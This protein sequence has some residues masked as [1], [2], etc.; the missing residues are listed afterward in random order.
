[1]LPAALALASLSCGDGKRKPGTDGG[2]DHQPPPPSGGCLQ[3]SEGCPCSKEGAVVACGITV[4]KD[5]DMLTCREGE[6]TCLDGEWS[7]CLGDRLTQIYDGAPQAPGIKTQALATA[8]ADCMDKC[9]PYCRKLADTPEDLNPGTEFTAA[10]SGLTLHTDGFTSGNCPDVVI[11]PETATIEITS[12]TEAAGVVTLTPN[13]VK[14]SATC[15]GGVSIDPSW[16]TDQTDRSWVKPDG[17]VTVSSAIPGPITVTGSSVVDTDTSVVTVKVNVNDADAAVTPAIKTQFTGPG[18]MADPNIT[19]YP[20]NDT[21]FPLDLKAPVVQWT[22][23]GVTAANVEVSLRYPAGSATPTF[24]YSKIYDGQPTQGPVNTTAGAPAWAI[25]QAVW[26]AFGRTA[27]GNDAEIIIQRRTASTLYQPRTIRVKFASAPL[28]GTVYYTQYIRSL[29][30]PGAGLIQSPQADLPDTYDPLNPGTTVCPVGNN[31]HKAGS[32]TRAIDMSTPT[33]N[34]IDPFGGIQSPNGCPVC[35]SVSANGNVYVAG[36]NF[37]QQDDNN[38]F[39]NSISVTA[40]GA[41]FTA[42]GEAP[43]YATLRSVGSDW[44]SRGFA[45]AALTPDGALAIQGP[46]WW[47]NTAPNG[48]NNLTIDRSWSQNGWIRPMFFVPTATIGA[49]V[50]Y[51]TTTNLSATR[52]GNVLTGPAATT[53]P[54]IDGASMVVGDSVLV[55]DQT[56]KKDNG[57][58]EVSTLGGCGYGT[59]L[60]TSTALTVTVTSTNGTNTGAKAIDDNTTTRWE[61]SASDPQSITIDLG[62]SQSIGRVYIDWEA[63]SA[64]DYTIQVATA[65]AGPWTT[66]ATMTN[67]GSTNHRIDDLRCLS[68]TGRYVR[69]AGTARST[70]YGYSIFEM[71]V[72]GPGAT[73]GSAYTLTRRSD[74]QT[75]AAFDGTIKKDWEVR[76]TRGTANYAKVFRLTAPAANPSINTD[77]LT[78]T[79]INASQ[80]P[81]MT[82][83]AI[84]PDGTKV[85]YVNGDADAIGAA[86]TAWRKGLTMLTLN[87]ATRQVS[88]K[89]RLVDNWNATTGGT[90]VKWPFFERDSRSVVYV[91][92]D[93]DE[94]C[95]SGGDY[96]TDQ[97]RACFGD[98]QAFANT[99]PTQRGYWPGRLFSVDSQNPATTKTELAKLNNGELAADNAKAFQ[100]TVLPFASGGYRWVIFTS[101]RSY[102]NQLNQLS[103][104]GT[105]TNF[106]CSA[107][108]LWI[109]AVDDS[110][111]AGTDRSHPAFL[112]PGQNLAPITQENHYLNERGYLV[113]SPCRNTGLSCETDDQCCGTY[114]CQVDTISA[115]GVPMKTCKNSSDCSAEGGA[116]LSDADCCGGAP[117]NNQK[118]QLVPSY[119]EATYQRTFV[120]QC[121]SGYKPWWGQ[122]AYHLT[123][124][125]GSH[126][127]FTAQTA[128]TSADLATATVVALKDETGS[129]FGG[130]AFTIDVGAKLVAKPVSPSLSYLRIS[131]T[132]TPSTGGAVS[133]TLHDWEQRFSCLPAE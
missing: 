36:S 129:N 27:A 92:T 89:T 118:C 9:E 31:T 44:D 112:L 110:T 8:A 131:M 54:T 30:T 81:V 48:G 55:K 114:K 63:A 47:G 127:N 16:K 132:F 82:M 109:A 28:R 87:Q 62:S 111:A 116:C 72:Y 25:P 95:R 20:Y 120:A 74:A 85:V 80:L 90:P 117:C 94:W 19:L 6:R 98:G 70:T 67:G 59:N 2:P 106:T 39:V 60:T 102:G 130:T 79:D 122:F 11:T 71:D 121:D 108:L 99:A 3:P 13:S 75:P 1:V 128:A 5:E 45:F 96:S 4:S 17:T 53:L 69:M 78:F 83:P 115:S 84:S 21:I 61:S 97:G 64:K 101:P 46:G 42:I 113:P 33:A 104:T 26:T 56:T 105:A 91:Q 65:L 107:T 22:T 125:N 133:P 37:L 41:T 14:L 23:G 24:W 49:N 126:V 103:S 57:I 66:I 77:D 76:V 40:S 100:P 86:T 38:G 124:T 10:P 119:V 15:G 51:A 93:P 29:F 32:T 7:E 43:N 35:H 123:N 50:R 73:G 52:S 88:G 34:N 12:I 58:Y 68:G 18:T